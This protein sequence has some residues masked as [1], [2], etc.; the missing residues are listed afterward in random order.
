MVNLFK[1]I[2]I[3]ENTRRKIFKKIISH[4]D[5]MGVFQGSDYE[6]QNIVDFLNMIWD[7]KVA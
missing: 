7:Y 4:D 1:P 6:T 3:S 5:F 2:K